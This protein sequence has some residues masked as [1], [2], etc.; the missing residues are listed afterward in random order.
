MNGSGESGI[1]YLP[2]YLLEHKIQKLLNCWLCT[3]IGLSKMILIS[4]FCWNCQKKYQHLKDE[5]KQISIQCEIC[6]TT[7]I[8][9]SPINGYVYI[10][11]NPCMPSLIK[12]G[13]TT[14]S[15]DERMA[16]L[17]S[18]TGVPESFILEA[19]FCRINPEN[20]ERLIHAKLNDYRTNKSREFF[21]ID[22]LSAINKLEEILAQSPDYIGPN[23]K[24]ESERIRR[25][26]ESER[27]RRIEEEKQIEQ[28]RNILLF[29]GIFAND[30]GPSIANYSFLCVRCKK[31]FYSKHPQNTKTACPNC[32]SDEVK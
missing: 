5:K 4:S 25:I 12:I 6:G 27:I 18:S 31:R 30:P 8:S 2:E 24:A 21:Q 28:K 23:G 26:E 29:Y 32:F 20:D 9:I 11:S 7:L 22:A 16:E 3:W 14:R 17:N 10:L 13:F 1:P 15:I 19:T